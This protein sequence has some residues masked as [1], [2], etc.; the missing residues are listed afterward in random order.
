M[1][2]YWHVIPFLLHRRQG[3]SSS[4]FRC[5]LAQASQACVTL[6][7]WTT[8]GLIWLPSLP[9]PSVCRFNKSLALGQMLLGRLLCRVA[10]GEDGVLL[11]RFQNSYDGRY[12]L[13]APRTAMLKG[14][15][16]RF[17]NEKVHLRSCERLR[18]NL[19]LIWLFL[20]VCIP[21][22]QYRQSSSS[23]STE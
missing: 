9:W 14:S 6:L 11:R 19:A 22:R 5:R 4:H 13:C 3:F 18:A 7:C 1:F 10:R 8:V 20:R 12:G 21:D 2:V 16:Q 15:E 23:A 17:H